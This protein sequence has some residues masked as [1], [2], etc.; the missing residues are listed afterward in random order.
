M[1]IIAKALETLFGRS[2]YRILQVGLDS[3]GKTT[4]LYKLKLNEIVTPFPTIGFNV[5]MIRYKDVDLTIWDVGGCDKIKPLWRHYYQNTQGVIFVVDSN[6]RDRVGEARDE[7]HRLMGEEELRETVLLVFANKQDLPNP[8]STTELTDKL[9][10]LA[11]RKRV[12]HIQASCALTG[13][14]LQEGLAWMHAQHSKPKPA[15]PTAAAT[16]ASEAAATVATAATPVPTEEDK[17]EATLLEWLAREDAPDDAFLAAFERYELDE[18]DHYTCARHACACTRVRVRV[19]M[20][21]CVCACA[22][23]CVRVCGRA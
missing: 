7:L 10:L 5:E 16:P 15:G 22:C 11:L 9:G 17:M 8:M 23:A 20:C 13:D 6:D 18:W 3:T 2:N 19:G 1:S 14:G 12:W 4:I 21:A